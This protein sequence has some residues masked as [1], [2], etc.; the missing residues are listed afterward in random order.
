VSIDAVV[1]LRPSDASFAATLGERGL[2]V[3]EIA[4]GSI[5]V[6]SMMSFAGFQ[7]DRLAATIWLQALGVAASSRPDPRGV[8]VFPDAA[9]TKGQTYEEVVNE[10][11]DAGFWL[12]S[13]PVSTEALE[14]RTSAIM[15]DIDALM[16]LAERMKADPAPSVAELLKEPWPP[17]VREQLLQIQRFEAAARPVEGLADR[18]RPVKK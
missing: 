6:N 14:A 18:F 15:S 13:Q 11:A 3:R 4:D 17:I 10:V 2:Y 1:L 12:V 9:T 16:A 8:L 5:L 7:R